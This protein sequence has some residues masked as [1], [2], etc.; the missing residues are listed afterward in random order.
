MRV[1]NK[2]RGWGKGSEEDV[3]RGG[4]RAGGK[5]SGDHAVDWCTTGWHGIICDVISL[6]GLFRHNRNF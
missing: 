6:P 1:A 3:E 4:G 5:V 2:Q